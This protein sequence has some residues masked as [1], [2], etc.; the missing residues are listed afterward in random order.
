M[1]AFYTGYVLSS[2]GWFSWLCIVFLL[3]HAA[4]ALAYSSWVLFFRIPTSNAWDIIPD[5]I[6]LAK[7][8]K[9]PAKLYWPTYLP[10]HDLLKFQHS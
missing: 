5:L 6:A 7:K 4:M 2:T 8:S 1:R 9:P 10:D 3:T